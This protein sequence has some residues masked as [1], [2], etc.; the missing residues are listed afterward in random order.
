MGISLPPC[1]RLEGPGV[2]YFPSGGMVMFCK[3][4]VGYI[5]LNSFSWGQ[6]FWRR[7]ECF[8]FISK[9]LLLP[10]PTPSQK[11]EGNFHPSSQM[12]PWYGSWS[13]KFGEVLGGPLGRDSLDILSSQAKIHWASSIPTG[14]PFN[15]SYRYWLQ[16]E[17][18]LPCQLWCSVSA[19]LSLQFGEG[20]S[21][22]CDL[23]SLVDLRRVSEF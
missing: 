7:T 15:Y 22:L 18:S 3:A 10:P 8:G 12:W 1:Q 16:L 6:A 13:L 5:W 23:N 19:H 9:C 2:G 20:S 11:L 4:P 21:L 17:I 14:I